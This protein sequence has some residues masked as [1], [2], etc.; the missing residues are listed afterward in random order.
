MGAR[1]LPVASLIHGTTFCA[2]KP[3]RLPTELIA[4]KPA[5]ADATIHLTMRASSAA[6][7]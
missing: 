5:A 3:P 2:R 1:T 4:A 7:V 6:I